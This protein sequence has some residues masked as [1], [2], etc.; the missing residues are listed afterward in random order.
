MEYIKYNAFESDFSHPDT[1]NKYKPKFITYEQSMKNQ[2]VVAGTTQVSNTG[3]K[4]T[5]A[6]NLLRLIGGG[7]L[8]GL[9]NQN[10]YNPSQGNN[11][12]QNQNRYNPYQ[13]QNRYNNNGYNTNGY[14]NNN[15]QNNNKTMLY[16]AGLLV[17]MAV[18]YF[19]MKN[20]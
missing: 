14:N 16:V 4:R 20:Q 10:R 13:N 1:S 9:Q 12:Y 3:K 18:I 15:Y 17:L 7:I 8:G 6:G 11:S 2:G 5:K 19:A